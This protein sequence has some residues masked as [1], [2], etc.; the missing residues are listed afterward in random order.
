M[1]SQGPFSRYPFS[2]RGSRVAAWIVTGA[3]TATFFAPDGA[4]W[5]AVGTS[6]PA[7]LA[8]AGATWSPAGA[9]AL[10]LRSAPGGAFW[11]ITGEATVIC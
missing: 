1:F 7:F 2:D 11:T 9:G 8:A 4:A 10:A 3:G 5:T 6:A